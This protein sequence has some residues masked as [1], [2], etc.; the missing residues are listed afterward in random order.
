MTGHKS[1]GGEWDVVYHLDPFRIP[2]KWARTA[3]DLGDD[4]QLEQERNLRYVIE[5]RA[6]QEL[7]LVNLED[8]E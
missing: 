6:K 5:T 1:K 8:M 7:Y 3:A 2:S 4:S